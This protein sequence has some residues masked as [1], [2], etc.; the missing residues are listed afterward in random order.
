MKEHDGSKWGSTGARYSGKAVA[1]VILSRPYL[2]TALDYGCGKGTMAH[3]FD[4]LEWTE[5]DPGVVGK[6]E[7]PIGRY[8]LVTCTDVMEHV[9]REYITSVIKELGAATDK[10]L[11]VDIACYLTGKV[12][13]S[14]PYEGQ[15]LHITI[16]STD[17]WKDLFDRYSGLTFLESRGID[18]VSKGKTKKRLQLTYERT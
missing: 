1:E 3:Y 6:Q 4:D 18:K 11:F 5:Y 15:D 14:G 8:D 13:G 2:K 17:E 10:V 12:F 9:E 16:F 7:K